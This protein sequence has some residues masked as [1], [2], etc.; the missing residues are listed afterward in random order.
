MH[1]MDRS[2]RLAYLRQG[3]G[4]ILSFLDRH[5][6]TRQNERHQNCGR[7]RKTKPVVHGKPPWGKR[8]LALSACNIAKMLAKRALQQTSELADRSHGL[9][10]ETLLL[11]PDVLKHREHFFSELS[12]VLRWIQIQECA[13]DGEHG[14]LSFTARRLARRVS[15]R[16]RLTSSCRFRRPCGVRR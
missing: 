6:H 13:I 1:G 14:Q 2:D 9:A 16:M 5:H 4:N 3:V 8:D 15:C 7:L 12:P 10:D 11:R